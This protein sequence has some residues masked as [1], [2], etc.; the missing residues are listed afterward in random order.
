M[1]HRHHI[2][3]RA[4]A[5]SIDVGVRERRIVGLAMSFEEPSAY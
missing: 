5:M 4:E 3:G 2:I 1:V